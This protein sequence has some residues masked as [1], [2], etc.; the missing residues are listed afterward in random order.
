MYYIGNPS[1]P[2]IQMARVKGQEDFRGYQWGP[3][4]NPFTGA[5]NNNN[6]SYDEDS[7]VFHRLAVLGAIVYDPNRTMSLIPSILAA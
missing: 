1:Q 3:F 7:A 6:A 5:Q 4:R 2:N